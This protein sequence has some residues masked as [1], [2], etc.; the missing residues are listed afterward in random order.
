MQCSRYANYFITL[1][2][3]GLVA[4]T[5]GV[6]PLVIIL[7]FVTISSQGPPSAITLFLGLVQA[8]YRGVANVVSE[9]CWIRNLLLEL[10][11]PVTTVTLVYCDNVSVV[12]LSGNPVQHQRTKHI[13]MIKYEFYMFL[14]ATKLLHFHQNT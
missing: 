3:I 5:L 14:L 2:Q 13:E 6:P 10:H 12:S 1:M 7:T 8:E 4:Q 11:C 9:C